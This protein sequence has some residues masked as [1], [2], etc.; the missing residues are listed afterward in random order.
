MRLVRSIPWPFEETTTPRPAPFLNLL[1]GLGSDLYKS[2]STDLT[3]Q[4]MKVSVTHN[5]LQPSRTNHRFE[6]YRCR[7]DL[8]KSV[9]N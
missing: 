2:R 5:I 1:A 9:R 3:S 7:Y 4:E 8:H 6:I